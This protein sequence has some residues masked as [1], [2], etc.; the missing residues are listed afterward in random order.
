MALIYCPECGTQISEHAEKCIK[1]GYPLNNIKTSHVGKNP[2]SQPSESL[3]IS[4]N[5]NKE[6]SH[7]GLIVAGYILAFMPILILPIVFII[8]GVGAGIANIYY[9]Q[10]TGKYVHGIVQ[11]I[12]A[13]IAG[14]IGTNIGGAGFGL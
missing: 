1:C 14:I 3:N 9:A 2:T 7:N 10:W 12:I 8:A 11:V 13:V 5:Q 6:N 4:E